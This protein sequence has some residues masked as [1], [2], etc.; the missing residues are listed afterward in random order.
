[1]ALATHDH[2]RNHN[3]FNFSSKRG[4]LGV[5]LIFH[6][7]FFVCS[8]FFLNPNS[9]CLKYFPPNIGRK[10]FF[11]QVQY[12]SSQRTSNFFPNKKT[13]GT[14]FEVLIF[15]FFFIFFS[16]NIGGGSGGRRSINIRFTLEFEK[17]IVALK[18]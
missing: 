10:L 17:Y 5:V 9:F 4:K 3:T 1:M 11:H 2:L 6:S 8:Y 16:Q 15:C 7:F 13:R 18:R 14:P 12:S